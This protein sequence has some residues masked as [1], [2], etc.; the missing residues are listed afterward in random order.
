MSSCS[1]PEFW[2]PSSSRMAERFGEFSGSSISNNLLTFGN[3]IK[4]LELPQGVG[5]DDPKDGVTAP[6]ILPK[7][8]LVPKFWKADGYGR[9]ADHLN[10]APPELVHRLCD[11]RADRARS[12][13]GVARCGCPRA[14]GRPAR[15]LLHPRADEGALRA[16][17]RPLHAPGAALVPAAGCGWLRDRGRL[18]RTGPLGRAR[19]PSRRAHDARNACRA[20]AAATAQPPRARPNRCDCREGG[21]GRRDVRHD[22]VGGHDR[23]PRGVQLRPAREPARP[24]PASS[25]FRR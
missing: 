4:G 16:L 7:L 22:R 2:D 23:L 15:P 10:D 12:Y 20:R 17:L 5:H 11:R 18:G 1:S 6:R 8:Y 13:Q 3:A 19:H 9:L 25:G 14:G 24:L 21:P